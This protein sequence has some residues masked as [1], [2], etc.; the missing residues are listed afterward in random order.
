MHSDI[1]FYEPCERPAGR[2]VFA[3]QSET[4]FQSCGAGQ[5]YEGLFES[6]L[7]K[8]THLWPSDTLPHT[9]HSLQLLWVRIG[10]EA[11]PILSK[12]LIILL[13]QALLIALTQSRVLGHILCSGNE[14]IIPQA[15]Q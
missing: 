4:Y 3:F 13:P 7:L 14:A 6:H 9:H 15:T 1:Y 2:G 12:H 11:K 8:L 10:E 5:D